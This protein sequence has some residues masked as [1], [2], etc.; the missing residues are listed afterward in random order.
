MTAELI[1]VGTSLGGFNALTTLLSGLHARLSVPVVIV[2]HRGSGMDGTLTLASLLGDR[3][4]L[5]VFDAE[6]KMMLEPGHAYLA[7]ADYHVLIE[8]R[9]VVALST[10]SPVRS[11]RPSIDVL[12]ESAAQVY[13]KAVVGVILTGASADGADGLR[14]IKARGGLAVIEDPASA[15]SPTMPAAALAATP[16][17][18]VLPLP[19]IADYLSA[20]VAEGRA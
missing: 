2:Q 6:D 9:N 4:P 14:A 11:A 13:G 10:D 7:P 3:S 19:R 1:V 15:E 20:L 8:A 5:R 16:T 12:F 18:A 17:A